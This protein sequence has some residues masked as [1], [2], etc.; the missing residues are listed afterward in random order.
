ME[1][2]NKKLKQPQKHNVS[3]LNRSEGT[4]T[5]VEAVNEF[6][7]NQISLNT[8]MGCVLIKGHDLHVQ[9]LNLEKGEVDIVGSVDSFSYTTKKSHES[10]LKRMFQ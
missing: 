6:D 5:G 4:I 2:Y 9:R 1:D 3:I 8:V 7:N 10:I